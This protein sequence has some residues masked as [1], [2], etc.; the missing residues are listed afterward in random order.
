MKFYFDTFLTPLGKFS[1]AVDEKGALAA[2]AFGGVD[3]LRKRFRAEELVRDER[4]VEKARCQI[5]EFFAGRR[6]GFDLAFSP[7]GTE[8]QRV[9]WRQLQRIPFGQTRSYAQVAAA[10]GRPRAARAVGRAIGS[11][12][13]CLLT[14]CHR[15]I[16]AD[17]SLAGFAFGQK[18][19]R[20]LL[21]HEERVR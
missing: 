18:L 5:G 3:A 7:V 15:V 19:K 20:Q 12:P 2:A 14:P 1:V 10:I 17:G 13:I 16:G 9:V 4:C 8:F 11:N 6:T 21:E